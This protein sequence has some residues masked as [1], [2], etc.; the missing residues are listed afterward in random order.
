QED[1]AE[2]DTLTHTEGNHTF[3]LLEIEED[4]TDGM[5][6]GVAVALTADGLLAFTSGSDSMRGVLRR[7]GGSDE[8]SFVDSPS[9]LAVSALADDTFFS[10]LDLARIGSVAANFGRPFVG[11]LGLSGLIDDLES[12]FAAAGILAAGTEFAAD[13]VHSHGIQL[14]GDSDSPVRELLLE[15]GTVTGNLAGGAPSDTLSYSHSWV[16]AAGWW[17]WLNGLAQSVP[18]LGGD[19]NLLVESMIGVNPEEGIFSWLGNEVRTVM[20]DYPDSADIGVASD[21]MLGSLVYILDTADADTAK[22]SIDNVFFMGSMLAQSMISLDGTDAPAEPE[23]SEV[24]GVEVTTYDFSDGFSLSYAIADGHVYFTTDTA[25]LAA[26]LEGAGGSDLE[27]LAG[28]VPADVTSYGVTDYSESLRA[29]G[30]QLAAQLG[31]LAGL[32][33]EGLAFEQLEE[34]SAGLTEFFSCV[35]DRT[36]D[37]WTY[38]TVDG[39][40]IVTEGFVEVDW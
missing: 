21:N 27:R 35:A 22:A 17:D 26:V 3:Y 38:T 23:L 28:E 18:E 6:E 33:G 11:E 9:Y 16:D 36:G 10:F 2:E 29:T 34:V 31:L 40:T 5:V 12:A 39:D 13:G 19:L 1:A 24:A 20:T 30:E 14:V 25:A 7:A 32:S 4:A 37:S 15:R 8:P